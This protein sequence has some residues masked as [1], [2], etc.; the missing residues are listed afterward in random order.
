MLEAEV[1]QCIETGGFSKLPDVV[2]SA[3]QEQFYESAFEILTRLILAADEHRNPYTLKAAI[4]FAQRLSAKEK[5][6][7]MTGIF[8]RVRN[9]RLAVA[10]LEITHNDLPS[11]SERVKAELR[12]AVVGTSSELLRQVSLAPDEGPSTSKTEDEEPSPETDDE[13]PAYTDDFLADFAMALSRLVVGLDVVDERLG[14]SIILSLLRRSLSSVSIR[15]AIL[16]AM[17]RL[18]CCQSNDS[19][20]PS[21]PVPV[22]WLPVY[23]IL[24]QASSSSEAVEWPYTL[25]LRFLAEVTSDA[26]AALL[27]KDLS[28]PMTEAL[29][30]VVKVLWSSVED[31]SIDRNEMQLYLPFLGAL[32][33]AAAEAPSEPSRIL[34]LNLFPAVLGK[35]TPIAQYL[36]AR[37][38]FC[39]VASHEISVQREPQVLAWLIDQYRWRVT[40]TDPSF[41]VFRAELNFFYGDLV[42]LRYENIS[43]GYPFYVA[44]CNLIR[45]HALARFDV[46]LV[47]TVRA[48]ILDSFADQLKSFQHL[49][50]VEDG[51]NFGELEV[52][53]FVIFSLTDTGLA[54]KPAV[55]CRFLATEATTEGENEKRKKANVWKIDEETREKL[56]N[57]GRYAALCLPKFIQQVQFAGGD[58]LELLIHP[59]GVIPVLAFLKG[60]HS[61]QFTN[62]SFACGVDVPTRKNRFEVV[63]SVLSV[64]FNAR[65]RVRTYTDEIAPLESATSVYSGAEWYERE[66]YDMYG[67]WFNNHPDLRRILTDYGFE[68]HPQRKDFPLTGYTDMR[69]DPELQRVVYEPSEL[70]QEFRKF[71]L[72]TPWEIFP[73]F[74]D[75]PIT[76]GYKVVETEAAGDQKSEK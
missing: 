74:R 39:L 10:L 1:I 59:S 4:N 21:I 50:K 38:L 17:Q 28:G 2:E 6:L 75:A 60:H 46:A 66:V 73:T 22:K 34:A 56:A 72:D 35:F 23:L 63:Y 37:R 43:M 69:F 36:V 29:L 30:N 3:T 48:K 47:R 40:S 52:L 53:D 45:S 64:R 26:V 33:K 24:V 62:F 70:S 71:D 14:E 57:F 8:H 54:P 55:L 32:L 5:A 9:P 12:D 13:K 27:P 20:M 68:G 76:S 18:P 15:Q 58:E 31:A 67:V 25:S 19:K 61:A 51:K 41:D 49:K 16:F 44:V 65:V 7:C 42:D 11:L